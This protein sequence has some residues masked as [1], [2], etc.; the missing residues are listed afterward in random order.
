[1]EL[2]SYFSETVPRKFCTCIMQN[3]R[4]EVNKIHFSTKPIKLRYSQKMS[5]LVANCKT[6]KFTT[7]CI[8]STPLYFEALLSEKKNLEYST[9]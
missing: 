9:T 4:E 7:F 1:M 8:P 2:I 3:K 5:N 6:H